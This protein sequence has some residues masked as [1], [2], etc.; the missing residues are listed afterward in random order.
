MI[1]GTANEAMW[2]AGTDLAEEAKF[3]WMNTG[4]GFTYVRWAAN[5][6]DNWKDNEHCMHL[7]RDGGQ[8][9]FNDVD[10]P[11]KMYYICEDKPINCDE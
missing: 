5:Q 3:V 10:C 2:T 8:L 4:K 6:P 11:R 1:I 9:V 7:R